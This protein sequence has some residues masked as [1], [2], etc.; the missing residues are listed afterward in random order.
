MNNC[1]TSNEIRTALR[2]QGIT[3][4]G[5]AKARGFSTDDV[6]AVL[7]GRTKGNWGRSH[8]IAVALGL[9]KKLQQSEITPQL[10]ALFAVGQVDGCAAL[11]E[12]CT[13]GDQVI[14]HKEGSME[15]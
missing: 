1:L 7:N 11:L 4:A 15:S 5:W 8:E 6:Y 3:V 12:S 13:V 10:Q 2:A 9:K 14:A